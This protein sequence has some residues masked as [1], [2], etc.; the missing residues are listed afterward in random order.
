MPKRTHVYNEFIEGAARSA[1]VLA[2]ANWMEEKGDGRS[3]SG[4]RLEDVAPKTPAKA[5]AW[6]KKLVT[7]ME[8]ANGRSIDAMYEH[9]LS[10]DGLSHEA[11]RHDRK[12]SAEAFGSDTALEAIGT[13]V[14]WAD[15]HTEHGFKIPGAEFNMFGSRDFYTSVRG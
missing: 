15:D 1:F 8:K 4:Q 9:A 6:A 12:S 2:W 5:K 11:S 3:L 10:I 13:G 7:A 14:S